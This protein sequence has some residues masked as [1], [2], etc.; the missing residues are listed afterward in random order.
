[1]NPYYLTMLSRFRAQNFRSIVDAELSFS[2]DEGK[3]PNGYKDLTYWPF[4]EPL[5]SKSRFVPCMSIYGANASGKTNILR[6]LGRLFDIIQMGTRRLPHQGKQDFYEPNKLHPELKA[7]EF[8]LEFFFNN[9]A[10][11]YRLSYTSESILHESMTVDGVLLFQIEKTQLKEC[12]ALTNDTYNEEKIKSIFETECCLKI[13]ENSIAQNR[14]L[15]HVIGNNYPGLNSE[16]TQ[17]YY[18]TTYKFYVLINNIPDVEEIMDIMMDSPTS[19]KEQQQE[20]LSTVLKLVRKFDVAIHDI[21]YIPASELSP[22]ALVTIHRMANNQLVEFELRE[23]S[24]GTQRLIAILV[25]ALYV[26]RIGSAMIVDEI[27]A[28]LHPLIFKELIRL[29]KDKEYNQWRSQLIFTTHST[30]I[31]EGDLMRVSEVAIVEK[32]LKAGTTIH[33]L[34]EMQ[35]LRNVTNFRKN[36]LAGCYGGI[37]F[38]YI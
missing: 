22:A 30:D 37:P 2:F 33:R 17:I 36:Y 35:G 5:K 18:A 12:S 9:N 27:D 7:T 25:F 19:N 38:P 28:H 4:L 13:D 34:S 21:K 14:C 29:F 26:L 1:M 16:L 32:N 24:D 15:L 8:E 6:A 11:T 20:F 23:E 10:C 3:A 31:L